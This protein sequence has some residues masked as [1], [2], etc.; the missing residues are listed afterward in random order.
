MARRKKEPEGFH[1]SQIA[2]A[3]ERLFLRQGIQQTSMD[4]IAKEAGY[5]KSTVYIYYQNK[6]ELVGEL[7]CQSMRLLHERFVRAL[8]QGGSIRKRYF[9]LCWALVEYQRQFP[10]YFEVTLGEINIDFTRPDSLPV[11]EATFEIG[12]RIN[13][14]IASVLM[15][16]MDTGEFRKLDMPE[17]IFIL[18]SAL[19]GI[20]LM[21]ANKHAYIESVMG[22]SCEEFLDSGFHTLFHSIAKAD[23]ERKE[24]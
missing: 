16:G 3:A 7:V 11:E 6:E 9:G 5:S 23:Y 4:S 20:I 2:E 14:E 17:T 21:A 22:K 24:E 18:W 1:R 15:E 10:F 19:S 8:Q 12:E 13:E